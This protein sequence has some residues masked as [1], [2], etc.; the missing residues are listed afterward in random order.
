MGEKGPMFTTDP[1]EQNVLIHS[2]PATFDMA[3]PDM[4][5]MLTTCGSV[6]KY[7]CDIHGPQ[8]D[9]WLLNGVAYCMSCVGALQAMKIKETN[10]ACRL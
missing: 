6:Y 7:H 1:D 4:P 9:V 2:Q 3:V 8:D 10:D 5:A